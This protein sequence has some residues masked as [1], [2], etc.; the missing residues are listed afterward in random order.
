MESEILIL[1]VALLTIA[2]AHTED[3]YVC[4]NDGHHLETQIAKD[5][6][7]IARRDEFEQAFRAQHLAN[8]AANEGLTV[9]IEAPWEGLLEIPCNIHIVW[10]ENQP[11][12]N[13][14][15]EQIISQII[16]INED[17]NKQNSD[18]PDVP[19]EFIDLV[20]DYKISFKL[21]KIK[22]VETAT[23][24]FNSTEDTIKYTATGGSDI[25][26]GD[27]ALNIWVGY[28]A[29]NTVGIY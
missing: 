2:T 25:I 28:I 20:A 24:E 6:S 19:D 10:W 3:V 9:E 7:F 14:N 18:W 29:G 15:Y 17:F 23:P 16:V 4:G 13:L 11:S 5:P 27:V 26:D 8:M 12:A 1:F 22:R 21:N